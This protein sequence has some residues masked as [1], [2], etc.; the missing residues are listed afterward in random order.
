M[1][2]ISRKAGR[3]D[4]ANEK[5][6]S[7]VCSIH[8]QKIFALLHAQAIQ[9]AQKADA[10]IQIE[11][12]AADGNDAKSAVF[13][14]AGEHMIVARSTEQ[15]DQ[16]NPVKISRSD[17][18]NALTAYV[19]TFCGSDVASG[20]KADECFPLEGGETEGG[21]SDSGDGED[22]DFT[23]DEEDGTSSMGESAR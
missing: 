4:E 6:L 18:M 8:V 12:T 2:S 23:G 11:N 15:D 17:A 5:A 20:L 1:T 22:D 13:H 7:P 16:K 19:S 14:S 10:K 3:L 21:S 9:A